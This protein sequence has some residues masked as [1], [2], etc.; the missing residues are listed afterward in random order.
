M[1]VF[2][3]SDIEGT[4]GIVHW[5]QVLNGPEY[6]GGR[7]LLENEVNAAIDGAGD[8]GATE[9][10]V[11][12][13]H[14]LMQNLRPERLHGRASLVSGKHKPL[15]MMEGLDGSF[16]AAFL[17]SY[18]G[19]ISAP[20]AVLSH[21]YNPS[22]VYHAELN[23]HVVGESGIN[24]LVARHYDVPIAL[25]TGDDATA[26]EMRRIAP[27]CECVVVK[28]SITRF[29][30]ESL[31]PEVACERIR[32]GAARALERL[33]QMSAAGDRP[34]RDARGAG[35][36][37]RLR[38]ARHLAARCRA[39]RPAQPAHRRR[40]AAAPVSHV[41]RVHGD[42]ARDPGAGVSDRVALVT[43]AAGGI[44]SAIA[45]AARAGGVPRRLQRPRRRGRRARRRRRSTA[46]GASAATCAARPPW[47]ELRDAVTAEL[48][49]P[50]LLVNAA[51]VFFEHEVTELSLEQWDLVMDVNVR[52]TFLT[53]R[54]LLPAMQEAGS[55]CIV[56]IASTAGLSG[57]PHARRL[58]RL[59]G[60]GRAVHAQPR[61]RLRARAACA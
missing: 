27:D 2:I 1:R 9:F 6:E 30:A 57:R 15:Y 60:R 18:H 20:T 53:C 54:A 21:T 32:A 58:Q 11:N 25:I 19:S 55:G 41:G 61:D 12:D 36:D 44:G 49:A 35:D 59:E 43:G 46:P 24:A 10:L 52:G 38:R 5:E 4:A 16:D 47:T 31:H 50:W 23:G 17:V 7:T 48:G 14:Y 42:H 29:A 51:G 56:N 3:S 40:R 45:V 34:A 37:L 33:G 22:V 39:H 28:R 13:A 26:E 8:A